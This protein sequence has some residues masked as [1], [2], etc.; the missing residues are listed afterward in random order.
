MTEA[1]KKLDNNN[2]SLKEEIFDC[3]N[4]SVK[5]IVVALLIFTFIFSLSTIKQESML[6]TLKDNDKVII[7]SFMYQPKYK[8]VIVVTQPNYMDH[9]LVKR[10][11]ATEGQTINIDP[12][13][14]K[15]FVDGQ[16]LNE[17]YIYEPTARIFDISYPITVPKGFVFVMGDN[18]NNSLDSRDS[19]IGMIDKR[20]IK[21]K[22][23][24]RIKP[25]ANFGVIK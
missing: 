23:V 19:R 22:V 18:R 15:V 7:Y 10:V 13:A 16:E 8:D 2:L 6:P 17:A 24:F 3:L 4:T 9:N 11:I 5:T 20:Y 14:K 1:I 12:I 21:G 25:L